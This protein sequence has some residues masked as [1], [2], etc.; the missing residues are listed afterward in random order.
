MPHMIITAAAL[1][2]LLLEA[3]G[4]KGKSKN[5]L[6]FV[7]LLGI[8]GA[9]FTTPALFGAQVLGFSGMLAGDG[10]AAFC[11]FVLYVVG[12][13][14]LL[15]SPGYL[16]DEECDHGEY[17]ALVLLALVG[18]MLMAGATH[19]L[20][21]FLALE[22]MSIAIYALAGYLRTG[23][24]AESSF[25][26]FILGAFASGFLLYG[27]ALIYGAVGSTQLQ[28][29]TA[30]FA[31]VQGLS[32]SPLALIGVG[33]IAVGFLFKVAAVPFHVWTPD[34]YQGAPTSVTAF[35]ATGVK[36][37]AFAAF[38]RVFLTA[39]PAMH[40]T[41]SS[42]LWLLAVL[43][44]TMG[45]FAALVQND[46][47]RMLAYSSIAHA[48]YLLVG[49]VVGTAEAGAGMLYY[50]LSYAFM[51]IG[52]FA[53]LIMVGRKGQD[54]TEFE[55][56]SGL[57]F[58][59]PGLGL[60]LSLFMF[61]MAGIPPTAGFIGKFLIFK[62]AVHEGYYWLTILGVLNSAASVYFYLR[63]IVTLYFKPE[64]ETA[65]VEKLRVGPA[66]IVGTACAGI[67]VLYLGIIP[68]S[69]V[70]LATAAMKALI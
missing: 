32:G 4:G 43:T 47:K 54:N 60:A 64:P 55:A 50:L 52:A 10:F 6:V 21:M 5:H 2:I 24:S 62:A 44:M 25:K 15:V 56:L 1:L 46:V 9:A 49:I 31:A 35:M 3:F 51:N 30:H 68:G 13:L 11:Y 17:Y 28:A 29:I 22:T 26:Y 48:G 8:A 41:T 27:I 37:A 57:G 39:F 40:G 23:K 19:L 45:N 38:I 53:C 20:V 7:G 18:M 61:S 67:A 42:A 59:Y 65:L 69:V 63:V 58:K 33:L 70:E 36:A 66:A 12:A 14:T 34:V 16:Q